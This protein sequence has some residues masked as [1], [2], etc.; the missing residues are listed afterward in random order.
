[1][2]FLYKEM[3]KFLIDSIT[4]TFFIYFDDRSYLVILH[5]FFLFMSL[6]TGFIVCL[7]IMSEVEGRASF[8][9]HKEKEGFCYCARIV[10]RLVRQTQ[11]GMVKLARLD[12]WWVIESLFHKCKRERY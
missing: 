3:F 10:F 9:F 6:I 1:M 11:A 5:D 4:K 12:Q 7:V 8:R 2:I